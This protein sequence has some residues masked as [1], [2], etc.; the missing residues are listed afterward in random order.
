MSGAKR[1]D[2]AIRRI[3]EFFETE[4]RLTEEDRIRAGAQW[5]V[6]HGFLTADEALEV[7]RLGHIALQPDL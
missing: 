4:A 2:F 5:G 6:E 1:A 7:E 3:D